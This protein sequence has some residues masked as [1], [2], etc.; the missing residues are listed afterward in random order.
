MLILAPPL[1]ITE[2]QLDD[3]FKRLSTFLDGVDAR[4]VDGRG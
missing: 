2:A 1:I 3:G 4:L